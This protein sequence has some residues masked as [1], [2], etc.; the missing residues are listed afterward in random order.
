MTIPTHAARPFDRDRDGFVIGEGGAAFVLE[1][2]E[3]AR[4]RGA[5]ISAELTGYGSAQDAYRITDTHPE[6]RGTVAAIRLA[7]A[8]PELNPDQIDY[9]NAHGTGT[10]LNDRIETIAIKQAFGDA[11][12]PRADLQHQE[13]AGPRD[14]SLRGDRAGGLHP[15]ASATASCRR[16]STSIIPTTIATSTTFRSR[17][18][19]AAVTCSA[20]ASASAARTPP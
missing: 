10:Q 13:H 15:G 9:V 2:L 5:D 4:R 3:H 8:T 19:S 14:H 12:L 11:R 17:A 16:R 7:L 6:G 1:S 18:K 20:T